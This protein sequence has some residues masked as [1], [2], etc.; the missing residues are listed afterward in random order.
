MSEQVWCLHIEGVGKSGGEADG[1]LWVSDAVE[2]LSSSQLSG[3]GFDLDTDLAGVD[4]HTLVTRDGGGV[5]ASGVSTEPFSPRAN[6]SGATFELRAFDGVAEK[7]MYIDPRADAALTGEVEKTDTDIPLDDATLGGDVV[8]VGH[9]AIKLGTWDESDSYTGST[10]AYYTPA[11]KGQHHPDEANVYTDAVPTW[12]GRRVRLYTY[13]VS[14]STLNLRWRGQLAS[15]PTSAMGL[16]AAIVRMPCDGPLTE[17]DRWVVNSDPLVFR[18]DWTDGVRHTLRV[19]K[20]EDSDTI[21]GGLG[22]VATR[23]R[24]ASDWATSG[25]PTYLKIGGDLFRKFAGTQQ[26][27]LGAPKFQPDDLEPEDGFQPYEGIATEVF[28]IDRQ[29]GGDANATRPLA[30]VTK[31]FSDRYPFHP[32]A[33]DAA[34]CLSTRS[35]TSTPDD[36]DIFQAPYWGLDLGWLFE[37]DII[38]RVHDIIQA[39]P[40]LQI[41]QLVIGWEGQPIEW[42]PFGEKKLLRPF[43]LTR[44]ITDD[45]N[46]TYAQ[47]ELAS[48]KNFS[49]ALDNKV[50]ALTGGGDRAP[51]PLE[52]DTGRG[53]TV[54]QQPVEYDNLPW[55]EPKRQLVRAVGDDSAR[56]ANSVRRSGETLDYGTIT[57]E[58]SVTVNAVSR[59]LMQHFAMPRLRIRVDDFVDDGKDYDLGSWVTLNDLPLRDAWL[60]DEDGDRIETLGDS[61]NFSGQIIGRTPEFDQGQTTYL[62]DILLANYVH[63]AIRWRGPSA[64]ITGVNAG[65]NIL[66]VST[67][68]DFGLP[69]SDASVFTIGDEI[70]VW[71]QVGTLHESTF[72]EIIDL[73][74]VSAS[75]IEIELDSFFS[76]NPSSNQIIRL[77]PSNTYVNTAVLTGIDRAYAFIADNTDTPTLGNGDDAD[78]YG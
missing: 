48:V 12:G 53:D 33:I 35:T 49:D 77:A 68:S 38:T 11:T 76:T 54:S 17:R 29:N 1:V 44:A 57:S 31:K 28:V 14:T 36:F 50:T 26:Q 20:S 72:P 67:D 56:T 9:E 60:V 5:D 3:L 41:D 10:R 73:E 6:A 63:G 40:F 64:R 58:Q 47:A 24:K 65:G 70:S 51:G 25:N 18:C 27:Q 32:V 34:V 22:G 61:A 16:R 59:L 62:L 23:V 21:R 19:R 43:G 78:T 39:T 45:G 75:V 30:D 69:E 4:N 46:L 7:F 66:E 37:D 15:S 55:Q 13:D 8:W 42:L 71:D 52:F 2:R 74:A